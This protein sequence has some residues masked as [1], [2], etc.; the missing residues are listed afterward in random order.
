MDIREFN[1]AL[2]ASSNGVVVERRQN[3]LLPII[4]LAVGVALL[5]LNSFIENGSDANN[6]KSALVLVGGAILLIGVALC[7]V[8]VFGGGAPYH[9]KDNCFLVRRQYSFDRAQHNEVVK[10]VESGEKS[11]IDAMAILNIYIRYMPMSK[12]R[13]RLRIG[14]K[15]EQTTPSVLSTRINITIS[16]HNKVTVTTTVHTTLFRRVSD[17]HLCQIGEHSN[18]HLFSMFEIIIP[19][20]KQIAHKFPITFRCD[21]E[22]IL[23][24]FFPSRTFLFSIY[25]SFFLIHARNKLHIRKLISFIK[26]VQI[27]CFFLRN[28]VNYTYN[29]KIHLIFL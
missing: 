20:I 22:T 18:V 27:G 29:V 26:F 10:A 14:L 23:L 11:A 24:L 21:G 5:V 12:L 25:K 3:I 4:I 1:E 13:F 16:L 28:S 8:R 2:Y 19:Q 6:L 7:G 9:T 17:G 15:N